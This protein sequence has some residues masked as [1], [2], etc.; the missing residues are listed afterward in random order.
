MRTGFYTTLCFLVLIGANSCRSSTKGSEED[1]KLLA[2]SWELVSNFTEVENGFKACFTLTNNS[3]LPLTDANWTLFFN[4]SPRPV[5][6]A[7]TPQP[8]TVQHINGDWYKLKPNK[9]FSLKPG[10]STTVLY[11]GTEAI[12]KVTDAPMGM[13]IV[14][15]D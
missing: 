6:P 4:M 8:A 2:V 12:T 7:K 3:S 10:A 14:F 11:E 15:Y 13:Y 1:G 5:L 9:G